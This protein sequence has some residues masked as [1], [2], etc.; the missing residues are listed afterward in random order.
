LREM[1][2]IENDINKR[3][4]F[5]YL[6]KKNIAVMAPVIPHMSVIAFATGITGLDVT[7]I[8]F[9]FQ[10]GNRL[11]FIHASSARGKVMIEQKTL[12]DYC[13]GQSSC[14]GVIVAEVL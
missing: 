2:V 3:G 10:A 12:N 5:Y 7:H 6:P 11:T 4:G 13:A 9:A 1:Q 14:T 8:G